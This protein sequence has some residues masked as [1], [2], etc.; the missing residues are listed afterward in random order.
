MDANE[1]GDMD[2]YDDPDGVNR[3]LGKHLGEICGNEDDGQIKNKFIRK[4][5]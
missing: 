5:L 2:D 1:D 4:K 3:K